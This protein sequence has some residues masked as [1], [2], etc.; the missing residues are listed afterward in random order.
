MLR[1]VF[2]ASAVMVSAGASPVRA[3]G[4]PG[5]SYRR[6]LPPPQ[7]AYRDPSYVAPLRPV[8]IAPAPRAPRS[9]AL[10]LYNEPPPRFRVP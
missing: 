1:F 5:P 7:I 2:F 9:L 4:E 8:L 10:P 3:G 6:P